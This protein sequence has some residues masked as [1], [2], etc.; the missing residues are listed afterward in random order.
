MPALANIFRGTE[1][2]KE[3]FRDDTHSTTENAFSVN[4]F[5]SLL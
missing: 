3:H 4:N 2:F 5:L 1:A